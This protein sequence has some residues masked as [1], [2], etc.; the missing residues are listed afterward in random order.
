MKYLVQILSAVMLLSVQS[1]MAQVEVDVDANGSGVMHVS[2]SSGDTIAHLAMN[3]SLK[4]GVLKLFNSEGSN[5]VRLIAGDKSYNGRLAVT[6]SLGD[7][8]TAMGHDFIR[9]NDGV[10]LRGRGTNGAGEIVLR[11]S[12]EN[13]I[14]NMRYVDGV[15]RLVLRDS[16]ESEVVRVG[17]LNGRGQVLLKDRSDNIIINMRYV[18]G[19]GQILLKDTTGATMMNLVNNYNNTG[20]SRVITNEIEINGGSDL[21]ELFDITS[22]EETIDAGLLVSLDPANPGKLIISNKAYDKHIA[23]VVSGAKGIRP[24]ILMGQANSL[25]TGDHLITLSGRTYIKANTTNG[26][27]KVGDLLTSSKISGEAMRATSRR[28]SRGAIIGKAMTELSDK[29]GYVLVLINLQ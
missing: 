23:G 20:K 24:G 5:T 8:I 7:E 17:A 12:F 25:A 3:D 27:I 13:E 14:I 9:I 16:S 11:D 26:K 15:G 18:N 29:S 22:S 10:S 2:T 4:G 21:A 6:D 19:G 28:K 1:A